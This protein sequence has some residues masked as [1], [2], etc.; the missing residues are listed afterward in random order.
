MHPGFYGWWKRAR[1]A[2]HDGH[3]ACGEEARGWGGGGPPGWARGGP[4]WGDEDRRA[5]G[6]DDGG[7]GFGVRR[8]LRFLAW[9]LELEEPQVA[10]L[11]TI[12]DALKTERAQ[13]SVD[14]RR[15][16]AALADAISAG[17]LDVGALEAAATERTR[18]AERVQ[19]AV[20]V[21]LTKIHAV[22]D[23]E[24]RKK[25]AYLLRTGQLAI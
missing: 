22:L 9:K 8:P 25:L 10:E 14:R 13:E 24:Q 17:A 18:S 19:A 23:E 2:G 5:H 6:G 21:A 15:A 4:P 3:H 20:V 7:G 1:H 12:L 11:A 16:T